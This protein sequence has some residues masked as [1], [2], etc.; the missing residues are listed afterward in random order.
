MFH[1][2]SWVISLWRCWRRCWCGRAW[3]F[4]QV[5]MTVMTTVIHTSPA[6]QWVLSDGLRLETNDVLFSVCWCW[7]RTLSGWPESPTGHWVRHQLNRL[8]TSKYTVQTE[9][10][11]C[12]NQLDVLVILTQVTSVTDRRRN[13]SI[14][15][16]AVQW[17][18]QFSENTA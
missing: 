3:C 1:C 7:W 17:T 12:W 5:T 9:T 18:Q 16:Q 2:R 11:L 13:K 8:I 10:I 6:S 15:K 4:I 14:A